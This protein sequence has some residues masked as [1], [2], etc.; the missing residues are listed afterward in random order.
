MCL[1]IAW[2]IPRWN[3][4]KVNAYLFEAKAIFNDSGEHHENNEE[5]LSQ[6]MSRKHAHQ[7]PKTFERALR[8]LTPDTPFHLFKGHGTGRP[9]GS[10][11]ALH[12]WRGQPFAKGFLQQNSCYWLLAGELFLFKSFWSLSFMLR[13][14]STCVVIVRWQNCRINLIGEEY[15]ERCLFSRSTWHG[16]RFVFVLSSMVL[17]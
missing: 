5:L 3:R 15:S 4:S 9:R 17:F 8:H 14:T 11:Y 13:A 7:D 10:P 16:E 1:S 12:G 2:A 6:Q